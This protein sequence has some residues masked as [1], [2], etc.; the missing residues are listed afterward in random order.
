MDIGRTYVE[1]FSVW[2]IW[3]YVRRQWDVVLEGARDVNVDYG[4]WNVRWRKAAGVRTFDKYKTEQT[5]NFNLII[6]FQS[7][8]RRQSTN[9]E[10]SINAVTRIKSG[11]VVPTTERYEWPIA[12]MGVS[13]STFRDRDKSLGTSN[14]IE[15]S[16]TKQSVQ[17]YCHYVV[18]RMRLTEWRRHTLE[19]RRER[20]DTSRLNITSRQ[21]CCSIIWETLNLPA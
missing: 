13:L 1:D 17:G 10:S 20:G 8:N 16:S 12:E 5:F 11:Q 18:R 4:D 9:F 15:R 7:L 6:I 14:R 19:Q 2:G 3:A 21:R